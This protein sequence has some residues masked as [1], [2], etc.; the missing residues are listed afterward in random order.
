MIS[1]RV[2]YH[3][4]TFKAQKNFLSFFPKNKG[5]ITWLDAELEISNLYIQTPKTFNICIFCFH[6]FFWFSIHCCHCQCSIPTLLLNKLRLLDKSECKTVLELQHQSVWEGSS[7]YKISRAQVYQELLLHPLLLL[8][9]L[10]FQVM[11]VLQMG[12]KYRKKVREQHYLLC[13]T[14]Y[15]RK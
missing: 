8:F 3:L 7:K 6:Q 13:I 2:I 14:Y 4:A 11:F 12:C 10:L 1:V 9:V 5:I 15:Y